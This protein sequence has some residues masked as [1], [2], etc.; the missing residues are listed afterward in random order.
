M[1]LSYRISALARCASANF[2]PDFKRPAVKIGWETCG[3]KLQAL[4]GPL[5]KVDNWLLC[6]PRNPLRLICGKYAAFATPML[7][8]AD[9]R[10]C[11][12]ARMSGRRAHNS[13]GQPGGTPR[14]HSRRKEI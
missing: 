7:A 11:S 3:T 14:G 8:L 13:G 9:T 2:T 5:N 1:V 6:P 12:A 4:C 10:I